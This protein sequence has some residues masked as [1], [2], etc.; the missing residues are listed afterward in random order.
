MVIERVRALVEALHERPTESLP[1]FTQLLS[2]QPQPVLASLFT[3]ATSDPERRIMAMSRIILGR[4]PAIV[5]NIHECIEP[6]LNSVLESLWSLFT[7]S[8]GDEYMLQLAGNTIVSFARLFSKSDAMSSFIGRLLEIISGPD[9]T[10]SAMVL[11]IL[12]QL[13]R[14][15]FNNPHL[16]SFLEALFE[17]VSVNM[18]ETD[19]RI[20]LAC[21]VCFYAKSAS[22]QQEYP[23]VA[24]AVVKYLRD[25]ASQNLELL[26]AVL[27]DIS[28]DEG[29]S[30]MKPVCVE[31]VHLLMEITPKCEGTL[32]IY[33][34]S[35]LF[36][37]IVQDSNEFARDGREI[38]GNLL[39]MSVEILARSEPQLCLEG[40]LYKGC[41]AGL[42]CDELSTLIS[43]FANHMFFTDL[44]FFIWKQIDA[45]D[46]AHQIA[47]VSLYLCGV[48][49]FQEVSQYPTTA[50]N[51]ASLLVKRDDP[52]VRFVALKCLNQSLLAG[53]SEFSIC[54]QEISLV[55]QLV[56]NEP[57]PE[58]RT[59]AIIVAG[60][61]CN[62]WGSNLK[63]CLREL[64][65]GLLPF[66]NIPVIEVPIAISNV[67]A[68]WVLFCDYSE[69]GELFGTVMSF[70]NQV[71]ETRGGNRDLFFACLSGYTKMSPRLPPEQVEKVITESLRFLLAQELDCFSSSEWQVIRQVLKSCTVQQTKALSPFLNQFMEYTVQC[72]TRDLRIETFSKFDSLVKSHEYIVFDGD[73]QTNQVKCYLVSDVEALGESIDTLNS[74]IVLSPEIVLP[75]IEVLSKFV[76]KRLQDGCVILRESVF[77]FLKIVSPIL[78]CSQK[79]NQNLLTF[80]IVAVLNTLQGVD[81]SVIEEGLEAV[82]AVVLSLGSSAVSETSA[83]IIFGAI[84]QLCVIVDDLRSRPASSELWDDESIECG[85]CEGLVGQIFFALSSFYTPHV[86]KLFPVI[87]PR[88]PLG[89]LTFNV[90]MYGAF[91][92][93]SPECSA[94]L[95]DQVMSIVFSNISSG[96]PTTARCFLNLLS[97]LVRCEKF[98]RFIPAIIEHVQCLLIQDSHGLNAYTHRALVPLLFSIVVKYESSMDMTPVMEMLVNPNLSVELYETPS[99]LDTIRDFLT[100][101][102]SSQI[103]KRYMTARPDV[104]KKLTKAAAQLTYV[105]REKMEIAQAKQNLLQ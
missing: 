89:N 9:S 15:D 34:C 45:L 50:L 61:V 5:P 52:S 92:A 44:C 88:Y 13:L 11:N 7:S 67:M 69:D 4:L 57:V 20:V 23:A 91:A 37:I 78:D 68:S 105:P 25:T 65:V 29:V 42:V 41:E 60:T 87:A 14:S 58:V 32:F 51:V 30:F 76:V 24:A 95:M 83:E 97:L 90:W 27:K 21:F 70:F 22:N 56:A 100:L 74:I 94:E 3:L 102:T 39:Q 43:T 31:L 36:Q 64:L 75:Y 104:L 38:I 99:S 71:L 79:Q 47:I 53:F 72:V 17:R 93:H 16:E 26:Q 86:L 101:L 96:G 103:F 62:L 28:T 80:A 18:A 63:E 6:N 46:S 85:V 49:D 82:R 10:A 73:E 12:A 33:A 77:I 48:S 1:L 59:M 8:F 35:L 19:P 55:L 2:E 98:A 81:V 54:A 84:A 40:D 66:L